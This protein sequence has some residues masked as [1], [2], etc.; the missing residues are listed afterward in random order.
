MDRKTALDEL[1][2][3]VSC[4]VGISHLRDSHRK[5]DRKF[6]QRIMD[7]GFLPKFWK[8]YK[9]AEDLGVYCWSELT[10]DLGEYLDFM[11][12]GEYQKADDFARRWVLEIREVRDNHI[13]NV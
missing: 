13:R 11:K 9:E 6:Y 3:A 5:S 1:D 2:S 12:A 4:L 7:E 10:F 8:V